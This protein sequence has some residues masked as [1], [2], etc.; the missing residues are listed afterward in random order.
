MLRL[1][2]L[3]LV[4][5]DQPG[6]QTKRFGI[7]EQVL[8][9]ASPLLGRLVQEPSD[10]VKSRS[11]TLHNVDPATF[12]LFARFLYGHSVLS[13]LPQITL[14]SAWQKVFSLVLA[15][16]F[17]LAICAS[18]FR[19]A[20]VDALLSLL[21]AHRDATQDAMEDT[22][23]R[24]SW[25]IWPE[26]SND[27]GVE[28][29]IALLAALS[30][31]EKTVNKERFRLENGFWKAVEM[32]QEEAGVCAGEQ[33]LRSALEREP[34]LFHDHGERKACYRDRGCCGQ[35]QEDPVEVM[36]FLHA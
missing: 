14:T 21:L 26:V 17:G 23:V 9:G 24:M 25:V 7:H 18:D 28:R 30:W 29:L 10:S 12:H 5:I 27:S 3:V 11:I 6:V 36:V 33:Y 20:V 13:A 15:Y 4:T 22:S 31:K 32:A 19:D 8:S 2:G 16:K 35:G 1:S 34:C